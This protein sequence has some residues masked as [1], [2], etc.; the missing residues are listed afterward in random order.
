VN[1][2]AHRITFAYAREPVLRDVTFAADAGAVAGIFGPNGSG[3]TTL[4]RCLSGDLAPQQGEAL[5]GEGPVRA[6]PLR[7]RARHIAIVAQD[8]PTDIPFSA[9]EVVLLGRY[10]HLGLWG[11][12][13][14]RDRDAARAAMDETGSWPLRERPFR[15]LSGGERQRVM[16]AKTLAQEP[17]VL[18]LDEPAL[19]LDVAHQIELYELL[20][21]LAHEHGLCVV[22]VCHDLFLAPAYLDRAV[23]L[24]EGRCV[25]DGSPRDPLT[26]SALEQVFGIARLPSPHAMLPALWG[27]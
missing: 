4:L 17:R 26:R 20:R 10:P 24:D 13:T 23:L 6:Y 16:I 27:A 3:K 11:E 18:L 5:L 15:E 1:V 14:E 7:E 2:A 21:H 22:M 8:L 12:E 25:G 19:H 9:L